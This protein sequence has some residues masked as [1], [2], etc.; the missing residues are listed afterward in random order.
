[1]ADIDMIPRSYRDGVR[2]QRAL[3]GYGL[4][5]GALLLAGVATAGLL[6]WRLAV[7]AP[8]LEAL[9]ARTAEAESLRTRLATSAAHKSALDQDAEAL[10]ALRGVGS[11]ARLADTLDTTLND[12]VWFDALRFARTEEL[13]RA[14]LPSGMLTT[15]ASTRPGALPGPQTWRV[16]RHIEVEGQALDHAALTAFL[17]ALSANPALADVRF[18]KSTA[19][20]GEGPELVAFSVTGTVPAKATP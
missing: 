20:P 16:A 3:R 18:V 4:A 12:K 1:M 13:L 10:A 8:Q 5:L 9:R 17:G 15:R 2:V 11:I 14:P 7:A 19:A 6:H